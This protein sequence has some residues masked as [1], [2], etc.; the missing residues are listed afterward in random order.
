MFGVKIRV[1][2]KKKKKNVSLVNPSIIHLLDVHEDILR[3]IKKC[4]DCSLDEKLLYC[5]KE[6]PNW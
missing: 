2:K 4:L 5:S 1:F 3:G 6:N